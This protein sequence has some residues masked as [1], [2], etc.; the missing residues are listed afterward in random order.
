MGAGKIKG[1]SGLTETR[2]LT[3]GFPPSPHPV[4]HPKG[5]PPTRLDA[6]GCA[7]LNYYSAAAS[8]NQPVQ[9]PSVSRPTR[10]SPRLPLP[11]HDTQHSRPPPAATRKKQP[12]PWQH[13][14]VQAHARRPVGA[15]VT[16]PSRTYT[17]R[18][19]TRTRLARRR[20]WTTTTRPPG[21]RVRGAPPWA[22]ARTPPRVP[23]SRK[24]TAAPPLRGT[25]C[26]SVPSTTART[27]TPPFSWRR[28]PSWRLARGINLPCLCHLTAGRHT[29]ALCIQPQAFS[30]LS[31]HTCAF[32]QPASH[33]HCPQPAYRNLT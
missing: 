29:R 3:P 30:C 4:T 16:S 14:E 1:K 27:T 5:G 11:C 18:R 19:A 28:A 17:A 15:T 10:L 24:T 7:W 20:G 31:N 2:L 21:R 8:S 23:T 25:L 32:R 6:T 12:P 33:N 26:R 22:V 9:Q 13:A